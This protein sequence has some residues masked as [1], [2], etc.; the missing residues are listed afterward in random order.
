MRRIEP[1]R[2]HLRDA[3]LR[4]RH[5]VVCRELPLLRHECL[6]PLSYLRR[7]REERR[8]CVRR[9]RPRRTELPDAGLL[10]GRPEVPFQLW[11]LRHLLLHRP[12]RV[13]QQYDRGERGVRRGAV[14]RCDLRDAGIRPRYARLQRR[15]LR[16]RHLR[17]RRRV[18]AAVRDAGLRS[19]P[20]LSG[21]VWRLRRLR[22]MQR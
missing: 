16:L 5:P 21:I 14:E 15:L 9:R 18:P 3:R 2:R 13:R 6:W 8:R 12:D 1:E 22:G 17:L 4:R 7:R 19:R 20:D 10:G 11:R